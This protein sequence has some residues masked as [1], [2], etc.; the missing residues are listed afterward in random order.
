M[1]NMIC[2]NEASNQNNISVWIYHSLTVLQFDICSVYST[3]HSTQHSRSWQTLIKR[4]HTCMSAIWYQRYMMSTNV[5]N[6]VPNIYDIKKCQQYGTKHTWCP[7]MSAIKWAITCNICC[8]ECWLIR[9]AVV[10]LVF[11]QGKVATQN[12]NYKQQYIHG[13]DE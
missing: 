9:S 1:V 6:M 10:M 2:V 7:K 13:Q 8:W 4:H 11:K 3:V 5:S 12:P